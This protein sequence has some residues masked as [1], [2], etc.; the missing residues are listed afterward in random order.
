[1]LEENVLN[2]FNATMLMGITVGIGSV[3]LIFD[4]G[5]SLLIQCP[6]ECGNNKDFYQGHG[7]RLETSTLLF[8]YLGK[9]TNRVVFSEN[10]GVFRILF[11]E[12]GVLTIISERNGL[13]SYVITTKYGI[14]PVLI[15]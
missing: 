9:K 8:R 5:A 3:I 6:F 4:S 7:E 1:M 15:W 13:E 2:E 10:D 11:E 14:D 12:E